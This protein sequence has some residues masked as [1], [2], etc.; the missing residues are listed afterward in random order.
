MLG[1][2]W[3]KL[4]S[5][6]AANLPAEALA[7]LPT[8]LLFCDPNAASVELRFDDAM[9]NALPRVLALSNIASRADG[10]STL[11][12]INRLG[13]NLATGA[14]TLV[15]VFGVL[16]DDAEAPYSFSFSPGTCQFRSVISSSFPRTTPRFEQVIPAGR[17]GWLKVG[18]Q[19]EGAVSGAA[20][21]F[22]TNAATT[23]N[24]FNQG[25]N[26]HKLTLSTAVTMTVPVFPPSC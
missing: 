11:L 10:N 13:G 22:N 12:V 25:H 26:L 2:A 7:A 24:A 16:Y 21:N 5:G 14:T 3:V 15:N 4:S 17:S 19:A 8:G 23:A 1:D 9:Y 6:H 20:L 18:T